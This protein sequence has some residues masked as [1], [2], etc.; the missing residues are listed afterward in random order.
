MDRPVNRS[1]SRAFITWPTSLAMAATA[2]AASLLPI[3]S[4]PASRNVLATDGVGLGS[5]QRPTGASL[6]PAVH[7]TRIDRPCASRPAAIA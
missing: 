6:H 7:S 2:G 1:A 3:G 4:P 5:Q